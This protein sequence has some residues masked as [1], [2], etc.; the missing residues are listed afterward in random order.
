M[1]A[2]V[3]DLPP[4]AIELKS[5][6]AAALARGD[7]AAAVAYWNAAVASTDATPALRLACYNNIALAELRRGDPVAVV[8]ACD[9][10][11]TLDPGNPKS[12]FRL[13]KA[14]EQLPLAPLARLRAAADAAAAVCSSQPQHAT[15]LLPLLSALRAR[16]AVRVP[17][18]RPPVTSAHV[19][20]SAASDLTF[21]HSADSVDENLLVLLHGL[22][23]THALFAA[24][25]STLALPQTASLAL[26]GPLA[27]PLGLPGAAWYASLDP[28]TLERY[29]SEPRRRVGASPRAV[30]L[31][32]VVRPLAAALRRLEM[33]HGWTR[34]RIHL[35]G[36]G[37]GATV[38][39]HVALELRTI[40]SV[41]ALCG[42]G[43]PEALSRLRFAPEALPDS[44][45][46][47]AASGGGGGGGSCALLLLSQEDST[48]PAP[49]VAATV[50]ALEAAASRGGG[51][52][53]GAAAVRIV[54]LSGPPRMPASAASV[55]PLMELYGSRLAR[56]LV[57]LE[58]DP[59]VVQLA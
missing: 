38:A 59:G 10:A 32:A 13:C 48:T 25:A 12:L 31:A 8:A 34:D 28:E 19:P 3:V 39:L 52:S 58:D 21:R 44:A 16:L 23:D 15:D 36:F 49:A 22:G 1:P 17:R 54:T 40:G 51:D 33:T 41:A 26:R 43:V 11:L 45:Q 5:A 29:E 50:A 18:Q 46:P 4:A 27:M 56:R 6:G 35:L 24:L 37:D 30:S 53:T 20:R 2:T 47:T 57:A 7:A 55:K 42:V 14:L 9:A